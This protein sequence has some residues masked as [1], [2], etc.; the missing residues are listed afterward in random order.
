MPENII[1][2][3]YT[4]TGAAAR[5]R[6]GKRASV[7]G[8]CCNALLCAAKLVIGALSG[9]VSIMA[10]G[11][12]NLSDA[13]SGVISLLG[14][15]MGAKP[16]DAEHPYG[17]GRYEY[18]AG[19]SV[20]VLIMVI[21]VELLKSSVT[22]ILNPA[23]VEFTLAA[24]LVLF[25]S[26]LLKAGM[27]AV[28]RAVGRRIGSGTLRAAAADSRNDVVTTAGVLLGAIV[29]RF[30][31]L[32]LDGW[33]GLA[34]AI[35]ILYSG[36]GLVKDTLDPLLGHA[37]EPDEVE[38]IRQKI[39]SYPGVIGTHDLLIHDYGPGRQ[40]ATAHVEMA[41]TADPLQ[42]HAVIDKIEKDFLR[43]HGLNMVVH[44]DPVADVDT[45]LGQLKEWLTAQVKT[46]DPA[47]SV[48]D[49]CATPRTGGGTTLEFDC[50]VPHDFPVE[51]ADIKEKITTLVRRRWPAN[52]CRITIDHDYAALP[53]T[54]E[55]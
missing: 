26:V 17:H 1:N 7:F 34:V 42:S 54:E 24:A 48:H 22:R 52:T 5:A 33:V 29:S 51:D 11:V 49:L 3:F 30:T 9:S 53:H 16:A 32:E 45:A 40:F 37:P 12:N 43:E 10:D 27:M 31:P 8:V 46:I 39:L 6:A 13:S 47:L 19:L 2:L 21:G 18:L 55:E 14:F 38:A 35:F 36:F 20:A 4:G 25:F 28:Y 44:M 50:V 23:P 41:A 15:Q